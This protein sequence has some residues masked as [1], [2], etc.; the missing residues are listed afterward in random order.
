MSFRIEWRSK[1]VLAQVEAIVNEV[2]G[3]GADMVAADAKRILRTVPKTHS[4][5]PLADQIEIAK[6]KYDKGGYIV[7]AQVPGNWTPPY[8]ASFVELGTR[9]EKR[10]GKRKH[11]MDAIPYLRPARKRNMKKIKKMYQ[12]QLDAK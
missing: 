9:N 8:R 1:I 7:G 5:K 12:Q 3:K 6:S 10:A 2:S 11:D 4:A